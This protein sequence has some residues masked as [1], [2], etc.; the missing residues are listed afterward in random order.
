MACRTQTSMAKSSSMLAKT[1]R[2]DPWLR[3]R[4]R[5][6]SPEGGE[7]IEGELQIPR[8]LAFEP[9]HTNAWLQRQMFITRHIDKWMPWRARYGFV[10][11]PGSLTFSQPYEL[12]E[13]RPVATPR[14][15]QF[16]ADG[17]KEDFVGMRV[18]YLARREKPRYI[19]TDDFDEQL[20]WAKRAG[21]DLDSK[22]ARATENIL[23]EGKDEIFVDGGEDPMV[24]AEA[25]RQEWGIK[26][27]DFLVGKLDEPRSAA[28]EK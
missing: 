14:P 6:L 18:K 13:G 20:A 10:P 11:V 5:L 22:A 16:N 28:L 24:V 4:V 27:E 1:N 17:I 21:V 9:V 25:R 7:W 26:R 12:L 23:P 8:S 3:R 2:R 19:T 15:A